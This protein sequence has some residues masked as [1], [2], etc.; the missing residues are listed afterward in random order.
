[1]NEQEFLDKEN[2]TQN[3]LVRPC[4]SDSDRNIMHALA[5]EADQPCAGPDCDVMLRPDQYGLFEFALDQ[6]GEEPVCEDCYMAAR[7][8]WEEAAAEA[9]RERRWA[10]QETRFNTRW[11]R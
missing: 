4:M 1:M 2:G 6:D 5:G 3:A 8:A 10:A 9:K 7:E 11:P